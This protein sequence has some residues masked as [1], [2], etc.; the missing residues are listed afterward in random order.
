MKRKFHNTQKRIVREVKQK[1]RNYLLVLGFELNLKKTKVLKKYNRQSVTGIVVNEK[2]QVS[3]TYRRNV[4]QAVY[5]CEKYGVQEHL[6]RIGAQMWLQKGE[7]RY[8]QHLMGMVDYILQVNPADNTFQEVRK[9]LLE[10]QR[11]DKGGK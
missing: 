4:R 9:N 1:V 8:L 10:M 2:A 6:R 3:K 7:E 11:R 5:Y